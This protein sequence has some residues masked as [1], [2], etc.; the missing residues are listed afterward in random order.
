M[1][2]CGLS[3]FLWLPTSMGLLAIS[4]CDE[5]VVGALDGRGGGLAR[6]VVEDVQQQALLVLRAYYLAG[7]EVEGENRVD[8]VCQK[9][10]RKGDR[11]VQIT[12]LISMKRVGFDECTP[13]G[14]GCFG[15][16]EVYLSR[17]EQDTG[18]VA[19]RAL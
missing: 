15:Y 9:S 14:R 3:V 17:R 5:L 18:F 6:E 12:R 1:L 19:I 13:D 7:G 16:A 2:N 10:W 4:G 11:T 8:D